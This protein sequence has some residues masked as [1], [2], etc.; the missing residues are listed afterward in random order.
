MIDLARLREN[1]QEVQDLITRKEPGFDV[2]QLLSLDSK[3]RNMRQDVE[4]LRKEKNELASKGAGGITPEVREKSIQL[5]KNLKAKEEELT[6]SEK[7]LNDLWLACPN[8]PQADLPV[9]NKE[10]NKPVTVVGNKPEFSFALKNH[11]ELNQQNRWFDM[12]TA[13]GMSGSGFVLYRGLGVKVIYALTRLMLKN[14][15]ARG[16]EP[17]LPPYL[18]NTK[19]MYN[20]SNLPKFAGD[21]YQVEGEDLCLIPTAE[22]NLT[23]IY[24]DKILDAGNLPSRMTAWTSCFRREAGTYGSTERGLIR[25]HQ[26]EK[27]ELYS[28]TEPEK[29]DDELNYMVATAENLLQQ[30]G[31]HYRVSLLATQDCSF[32]SSKTFDIEVWLPG[33]DR[34]YEVSSC[35]NCTDFQARRAQIRYRKTPESK[36]SLVHT[37]NASALALP[38]L[39]VALMENFQQADGSIVLPPILEAEIKNLW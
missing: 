21:Y 16:F 22:V 30:L 31:L 26:F 20:A 35:S 32:A 1:P 36:P 18:I 5:G 4:A 12:E 37:L 39:M 29:S 13:A 3:L 25:I 15:A 33:Q 34:Y 23:N 38:R 6:K 24:A 10:A 28:I 8:V 9:G 14:N 17:V 7:E 2:P 19:G 27:V 11:V